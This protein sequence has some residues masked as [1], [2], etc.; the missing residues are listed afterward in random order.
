MD[1][2]LPSDD[3]KK[4]LL[5]STWTWMATHATEAEVKKRGRENIIK[6]F[7]SIEKAVEFQQHYLAAEATEAKAG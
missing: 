5:L 3:K 7:G 6:A 1:T 4:Y 2:K